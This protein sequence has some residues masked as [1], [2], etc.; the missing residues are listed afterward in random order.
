MMPDPI[1]AFASALAGYSVKKAADK[2][3]ERLLGIWTRH[4]RRLA[5]K[6]AFVVA[7]NATTARHS[8]IATELFSPTHADRLRAFIEGLT[9]NPANP[10][11]IDKLC[12]TFFSEHFPKLSG[13]ALNAA[14]L[15][16]YR[17]PIGDVRLALGIFYEESLRA[18]AQEALLRQE[19]RD[20]MLRQTFEQASRA[21]AVSQSDVQLK[22]LAP[23]VDARLRAE[24]SRLRRR[25]G[26]PT[27]NVS[28]EINRFATNVRDGEF[29][30]ADGSTRAEALAF[31]AQCLARIGETSTAEPLHAQADSLGANAPDLVYDAWLALQLGDANKANS[32]A[33]ADGSP[34]GVTLQ[35]RLILD[36]DGIDGVRQEA[37]RRDLAV[38]ELTGGGVCLV[39]A[40]R[41]QA[42][43]LQGGLD[44][45][46]G[47]SREQREEAP[48][49][50]A[51]QALLHLLI[52][53]DPSW[54]EAIET[55]QLPIDPEGLFVKTDPNWQ[56]HL[57]QGCEMFRAAQQRA[58]DVGADS[59][60]RLYEEYAL[61]AAL[62]HPTLALTAKQELG[63][64]MADAEKAPRLAHIANAFHIPFDR[65]RTIAAIESAA[66]LRTLT[67][68][69]IRTML[70]VLDNPATILR[71]VRTYREAVLDAL[72]PINASIVEVEMLAKSGSATEAT[73][74]LQSLSSTLPEDDVR[75]M[76]ALVAA[77]QG[78]D[79]T[80]TLKTHFDKT[81]SLH[82]LR[83]LVEALHGAKRWDQMAHYAG[84]LFA[85]TGEA[86]DLQNYAAVLDEIGQ[87]AE[88]WKILTEAWPNVEHTPAL[89]RMRARAASRARHFAASR[90]ALNALGADASNADDW[91]IAAM[92][93]VES[94][95]W[96]DIRSVVRAVVD[97]SAL[98]AADFVLWIATLALSSDMTDEAL[99][100]AERAV[101]RSAS[102]PNVLLGAHFIAVKL[103]LEES[104]V[105]ARK[106]FE[107]A[108][109]LSD[110]AGPVQQKS[111]KDMAEL[112]PQWAEQTNTISREW[113]AGTMPMFVAAGPVR[114]NI[115]DLVLGRALQNRAEADPRRR[116]VVSAF[117]GNGRRTDLSGAQSIGF[118]VTALITLQLA[119]CLKEALGAASRI[120]LP[121]WTL[122]AL[123][124]ASHEVRFHQPSRIKRAEEIRALA[125]AGLIVSFESRPLRAD[126]ADEV[127]VDLAGMLEEADR[128]KG[129][130]VRPAPLHR[131]GTLLEI[132]VPLSERSENVTDLRSV[133]ATL[134]ATG[135]ITE[136]K[137]ASAR[138]F[139]HR[140]DQG[141]GAAHTLDLSRPLYLDALAADYLQGV[142]LFRVLAEAMKHN[143]STLYVEKRV[144][145]DARALLQHDQI[146]SNTLAAINGIRS[147]LEASIR[148]GLAI[149]CPERT[150]DDDD[151]AGSP[152][153]QILLGA[154]VADCVIIDDRSINRHAFI[155]GPTQIATTLDV[156]DNL[157]QRQLITESAWRDARYRLREAGYIFIPL[158][159]DE[160]AYWLGR[161]QL[162]P[163][164]T[165]VEGAE[166]RAIREG[167]ARALLLDAPILPAEA[168]ALQSWRLGLLLAVRRV[169]DSNVSPDLAIARANWCVALLPDPRDLNPLRSTPITEDEIDQELA[170]NAV[171]MTLHAPPPELWDAFKTWS[172]ET[173]IAP[174]RD[175]RPHA[176][177]LCIAG[178]EDILARTPAG[179]GDE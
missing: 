17:K 26:F 46:R 102:D 164:N 138:P 113:L 176:M 110:E 51:Q 31:C 16:R 119:G 7:A 36:Q 149:V 139:L 53:A 33:A 124:S 19:W 93:A 6:R 62:H 167:I 152:T 89:W 20:Q 3:L 127:G 99:A 157:R 131:S 83:T 140:L 37:E 85:R 135:A 142:N 111:I 10:P 1:G 91:R 168:A 34:R 78:A 55:A 114:S 96:S 68:Y 11:P 79:P 80:E 90:E 134:L 122:T 48:W 166:L 162:D 2:G 74:L 71:F 104:D 130:V 145:T 143:N 69:E 50:Y 101:E 81:N 136:Q 54:R 38:S 23:V 108:F 12:R 156:L 141:W 64:L 115:V 22:N 103:G 125:E 126:L 57:E 174:L 65:A 87:T 61:L 4:Q 77:T 97:R 59:A 75:R 14:V 21:A 39:A 88:A 172:E 70:A 76:E 15:K 29:A 9:D 94:G 112:A 170:Q 147:E 60:A 82:D 32:I 86:R 66:R 163:S 137:E 45:A 175:R 161:A 123:F 133:L 27:F 177:T 105:R 107:R 128:T 63:R 155:G 30:I 18:F 171:S 178:I 109:A 98:G 92:I 25:Q 173:V 129:R 35:L 28:E 100:L 47:A 106:W 44:F 117:F 150:S 95:A 73:A 154:L 179:D 148:S 58:L 159:V 24:I 165:L 146:A 121:A 49:L 160:I 120:F 144:I 151:I 116:G 43:D 42:G 52:V 169:W 5:F 8:E 84:K 153:G 41:Q 158:Y 118:D 132:E 40:A 72:G 67:S 13:A 56:S